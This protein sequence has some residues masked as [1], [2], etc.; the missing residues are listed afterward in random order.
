VSFAAKGVAVV[1]APP[2]SIAGNYGFQPGDIIREVNGTAINNVGEL[3]HALAAAQSWQMVIERGG[4]RLNLN[5]G[6]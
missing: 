6:G 3:T 2:G 4:R 5:V 1:A